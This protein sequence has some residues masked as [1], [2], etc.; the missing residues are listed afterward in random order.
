MTTAPSGPV[1]HRDARETMNA[2]PPSSP[3]GARQA[4]VGWVSTLL[5]PTGRLDR[6]ATAALRPTLTALSGLS[7]LVVVDL[8]AVTMVCAEAWRML[9]AATRAL[10]AR[11]G[12]LIVTGV[13]E[14]AVPVDV[15]ALTVVPR[16]RMAALPAR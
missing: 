1:A 8:G 3:S 12:G 4:D 10:D 15:H 11:G 9:E 16:H 14:A 2:S 7:G 5:R 6:R 13:S